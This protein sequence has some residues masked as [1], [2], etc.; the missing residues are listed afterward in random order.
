MHQTDK[1][2]EKALPQVNYLS[3]KLEQIITDIANETNDIRN[4]IVMTVSNFP[5]YT[6]YLLTLVILEVIAVALIYSIIIS[7]HQ[8]YHKQ[9]MSFDKKR[10]GKLFRKSDKKDIQKYDTKALIYYSPLFTLAA[11][12]SLTIMN[13]DRVALAINFENVQNAKFNY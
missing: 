8:L 6:V 5:N 9:L 2:F 12:K 1:E 4:V 3:A 10:N 13:D 7:F 11:R